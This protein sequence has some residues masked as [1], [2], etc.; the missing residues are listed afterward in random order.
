M[1]DFFLAV[2]CTISSLVDHSTKLIKIIIIY[3][4]N[5]KAYIT[6]IYTCT[7]N[8]MQTKCVHMYMHTYYNTITQYMYMYIRIHVL[9]NDALANK[10]PSGE[11]LR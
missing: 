11:N 2:I 5:N 7:S 1:T 9:T 3:R 8:Y 4:Y 6:Y 10:L